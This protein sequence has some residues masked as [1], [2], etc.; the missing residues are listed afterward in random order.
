M[1]TNQDSID[2]LNQSVRSLQ[3]ISSKLLDLSLSFE[4]TGN[5][6]VAADLKY[7]AN[8]ISQ[9]SQKTQQ[10]HTIL[11]NN[12]LHSALNLL[13]ASSLFTGENA[14]VTIR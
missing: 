10:A 13:E 9:N 4:E 2:L 11:L 14:H 5:P 3:F 8:S 1:P 7:C 12:S 6:K